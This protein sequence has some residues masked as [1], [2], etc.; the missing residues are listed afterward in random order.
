VHPS[1]AGSTRQRRSH[2]PRLSLSLGQV[3]NNWAALKHAVRLGLVP[4]DTLD[5]HF[6]RGGLAD[7][8]LFG[9]EALSGFLKSARQWIERKGH[10]TAFI[11]VLENRDDGEGTGMH[12][13]ILI[14]VPTALAARFH[15]LKRGWAR[16]AGL[17]MSVAGVINREP[18]PTLIA[19]I[20]KLKYMSKD[21]DP[22]AMP[23]FTIAGRVHLDDR[24][25]PSDQPV[26]GKKSGLSRNIDAGA[27]AVHRERKIVARRDHPA[28]ADCPVLP[29]AAPAGGP[30]AIA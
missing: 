16:R 27:R 3:Y 24:G 9:A 1:P 8:R 2:L 11:W 12:A 10:E 28:P 26:Y 29:I 5:V 17:N 22:V 4:T 13:H 18:L 14:H 6:D 15:Q 7:P 20:G 25:K 21:L 30:A 23:I 19:T